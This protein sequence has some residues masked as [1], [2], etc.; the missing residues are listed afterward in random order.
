MLHRIDWVAVIIWAVVALLLIALP[1]ILYK[2]IYYEV[3]ML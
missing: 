3:G 2:I 1:T